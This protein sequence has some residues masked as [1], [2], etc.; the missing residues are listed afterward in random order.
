MY[1]G[2]AHT[3]ML[4]CTNVRALA[5]V[6]ELRE[7]LGRDAASASQVRNYIPSYLQVVNGG[8]NIADCVERAYDVEGMN[9]GAYVSHAYVR[10]VFGSCA[11]VCMLYA[12]VAYDS[13][14]CAFIMHDCV[15]CAFM[16]LTVGSCHCLRCRLPRCWC[17]ATGVLGVLYPTSFQCLCCIESQARWLL[18]A[19]VSA[20]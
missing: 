9:V 11:I 2:L 16:R 15:V 17:I 4:P 20:C 18:V 8:W 19:L 5:I 12:C 10:C 14:C 13:V 6:I 3:R 7:C 1:L